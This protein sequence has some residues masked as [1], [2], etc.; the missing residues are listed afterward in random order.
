MATYVLAPAAWCGGWAWKFVVPYLRDA[1]HDAYPL[2]LTGMGDRIHLAHPDVDLDTHVLDVVNVLEYEDL[3]DVI[4]VGWSYAAMV[5]TAVA[6]RANARVGRVVIF[7]THLVP[8]DGQA[9]Y[10]IAPEYRADDEALLQEGN[11]WQLP[12]PP[13]AAFRLSVPDPELRTWFVNR[14]EPMPVKTQTQPARLGNPEADTLPYTL[15]RCTQS[16]SWDEA[17]SI[18]FLERIRHDPRWE[19]LDLDGRHIAPVAQPRDTAAVL[20]QVGQPNA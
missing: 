8:D 7:D 6:H 16:P 12:P 4:L 3:T 20:M 9:V 13:E 11:G 18:G 19:I 5:V 15:V 1:G 10:D 2:T 14:L 17:G